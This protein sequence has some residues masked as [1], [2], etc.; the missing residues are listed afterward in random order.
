MSL[1]TGLVGTTLFYGITDS[2]S[3]TWSDSEQAVH[4]AISEH[5][6]LNAS[7]EAILHA[8]SLG[9]FVANKCRPITVKFTSSETKGGILSEHA[10]FRGSGIS[11]GEDFC[12]TTCSSCKKLVDYTKNSGWQYTFCSNRM[13]INEK[14]NVIYPVTNHVYED[15]ADSRAG[16][17]SQY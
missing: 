6:N 11:V 7:D 8:H 13:H 16:E 14:C 2:V 9:S 5:T 3:E 1:K 4:E 10:K 17:Q 12:R 15:H